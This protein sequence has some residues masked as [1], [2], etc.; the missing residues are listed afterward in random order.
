MLPPDLDESFEVRSAPHI[1]A[2][3]AQT[4]GVYDMADGLALL[5]KAQELVARQYA[6]YNDALVPAFASAGIRIVHHQARTAARRRWGVPAFQKAVKPLL[7][8][9]ALDPAH[10]FRRWPINL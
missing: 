4:Q 3:D 5:R 8:P 10:P 7:V 6:L 2:V 9:V 1:V